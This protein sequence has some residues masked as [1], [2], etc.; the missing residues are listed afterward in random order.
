MGVPSLY[1]WLVGKYPNIVVAAKKDEGGAGTSSSLA[2]ASTGP[3]GVGVYHNLYL[4]M[5]GIIHPCFHPEDQVYY[6]YVINTLIILLMDGSSSSSTESLDELVLV[7]VMDHVCRLVN[8]MFL[9]SHI[10]LMYGSIQFLNSTHVLPCHFLSVVLA[11]QKVK[12]T[13]F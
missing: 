5:N 3:N 8:V 2:E 13:Q 11:F 10:V 4:D 9:S 1:K 6:M 7:N 12:H